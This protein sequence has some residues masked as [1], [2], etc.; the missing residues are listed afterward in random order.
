MLNYKNKSD[1]ENYVIGLNTKI[2]LKNGSLVFPINFDNAATTPPFVSV[3]QEVINFSPWYSSIHRG[4]GYKSKLCSTL[5]D[6]FREE[7]LT[8]VNG[9]LNNDVVI[10]T[11][12]TTEAINKLSNI[13]YKNKDDVVLCSIMEHHSNLLPWRSKFEVDYIDTDDLLNLSLISLEEKL[14]NYKGRVKLVAV[15]GASNVT[16]YVNP[17][18]QIAK[19]AHRYNAKIFVDGA[20]LVPHKKVD[21]NPKE[22]GENIDY[23]AFSAHKMYA[24]FGIGVLIGKKEDFLDGPPDYTGGGTVKIVTKDSVTWAEPPD[25]EEAGS[26][27]IIGVVALIAAIRTLNLIGMDKIESYEN[28][29]AEYTL[30]RLEKIPFIKLYCRSS[31]CNKVGIIPFNIESI[32]HNVIANILSDEGGIAVRSGCFCAQ[33][34]VQKILNINEEEIKKYM[35]DDNYP[36]RGMVRISFGLYNNYS[37]VDKLLNL[38]YKICFNRELY[39][40]KYN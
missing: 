27:N 18:H 20:Q 9:D 23:I 22:E 1:F 38:L 7:I 11:K 13:I 37:E 39:I 15:T 5:Y 2:P 16:G 4:T 33:P 32:P 36:K 6:E 10:F 3:L 8:F 31:I 34:Y 25:K 35:K 17:I 28:E 40:K 26:P 29:L 14:I 21:L 12:N 30:E 24:P 19:I